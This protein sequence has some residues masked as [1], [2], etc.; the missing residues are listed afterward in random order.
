[1]MPKISYPYIRASEEELPSEGRHLL[2]TDEVDWGIAYFIWS[3]EYRFI[4]LDERL[5]NLGFNP[6]HW[7]YLPTLGNDDG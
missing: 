7:A 4:P 1:M 5:N 3:G 2:V 6:T